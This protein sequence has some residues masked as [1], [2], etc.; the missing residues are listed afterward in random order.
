MKETL[1]IFT[2][3]IVYSKLFIKF[4]TTV[5]GLQKR[6]SDRIAGIVVTNTILIGFQVIYLRLRLEYVN[7][8]IPFWY[9]KMWGDYQLA[10]KVWLN[11]FPIVS[12]VI[13]LVGLA[14]T[15]PI[16]RY[17]I[18]YGVNL[19]GIV[20]TSANFLLTASMVKIIFKASV[21]FEPI[22]NPLYLELLIP[23]LLSFML[24]QFILPRF[25]N[26]AKDRDIVTSPTIHSHPGMLL[27][28]P[29]ARG[30]G[31]VYGIAFLILSK[32]RFSK[33]VLTSSSAGIKLLATK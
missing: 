1:K 18:R 26:Y 21:P 14:F 8:Q 22:I 15:I 10:D 32:V 7:S 5:E 17:F 13:L 31:F 4:K 25:I 33:N 9:T 29:S 6:F 23:A 16:K 28:E 3:K 12:L 30:G 27:S 20:A 11:L 2:N 19:I 24:V